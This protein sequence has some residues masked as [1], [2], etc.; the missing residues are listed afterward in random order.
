MPGRG[1][2]G[3]SEPPPPRRGGVTPCSPASRQGP[4]PWQVPGARSVG[5]SLTCSSNLACRSNRSRRSSCRSR[6]HSP[7]PWTLP[8]VG[9][10]LTIVRMV[11]S[12][13]TT[14][15]YSLPNLPAT[16]HRGRRS[17]CALPHPAAEVPRPA[18]RAR[19]G[20]REILR[21]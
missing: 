4:R 9:V 19:T 16:E 12:C 3:P 2:L 1:P 6:T 7:C 10:C 11:S 5:A 21:S 15:T 13:P 8:V 18:R 20:N 14:V 17:W